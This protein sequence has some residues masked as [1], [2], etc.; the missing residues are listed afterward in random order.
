MTQENFQFHSG[1]LLVYL[2]QKR[3][4]LILISFFA[5]VVSVVVSL[6]LTPKFESKTILFPTSSTSVS[7]A[8]VSSNQFVS[9]KLLSFGE[10]EEVERMLQ[11]LY[12]DQIRE[13]LVSKYDLFRHYDI[14]P[15]SKYSYT[16]L[17]ATMDKNIRFRK[18]EFMSIEIRVLDHSPKV[19]ADMANDIAILIDSTINNMQREKAREALA[20]VQREYE[21][22]ED[23]I[24]QVED[25]IRTI[26]SMGLYDYETQSRVLNEAYVKA[27]AAGNNPQ[28]GL[29]ENKLKVLA[30]LG[31]SY[32]S[33]QEFL[34]F[35]NE[36]LS[37]LKAK[38]LQAKVDAEQNLPHTFIVS[39]AYESEKKAWPK[40][41]VIVLTATLSSF[42]LAIILLALLDALKAVKQ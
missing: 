10:E 4:P 13:R 3:L 35:E 37:H 24:R 30:E 16:R 42:V 38:L 28:A 1:N 39:K 20:I 15:S 17:F 9:N 5:A 31:Q 19:A 14:D 8:L 18:T 33:L 32:L 7:E 40:R 22:L 23:E 6:T 34:R 26:R 27:I 21:N 2:W 25:S 36:R 29:I 41:S 12:S 11:I